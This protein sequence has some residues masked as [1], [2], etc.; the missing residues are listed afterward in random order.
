MTT[1]DT[2][3]V[4]QVKQMNVSKVT[5]DRICAN[6]YE[7]HALELACSEDRV[8]SDIKFASFGVPTGECGSFEKGQCES[9]TT[10]SVLRRRCLG[11]QGCSVEVLERMLGPI[12]CRV[13]Q[14]RLAVGANK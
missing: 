13:P 12:R 11:K 8:I 3:L 2:K 1:E 5:V 4:M 10:L 14:N 7:G 9:P 6:T